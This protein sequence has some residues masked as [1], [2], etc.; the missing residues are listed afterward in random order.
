M[1]KYSLKER[2]RYRFDTIMSKGTVSMVSMLAA[3]TVAAA[4]LIAIAVSIFT[5]QEEGGFFSVLWDTLASI[6]NA[7]FLYSDDGGVGYLILMAAGALIGVLFTSVLIGIF[8]TEVEERLDAMKNGRSRIIEQGHMV[9]LG[10]HSGTFEV[11][12][13]LCLSADEGRKCIV[14]AGE[15]EQDVMRHAIKENVDVPKRIRV[16]C[17]S[18][19]IYDPSQ[20]AMLSI[21]DA[22]TV[23]IDSEHDEE[24]IRMMLAVNNVLQDYPES[25]VRIAAA[26]HHKATYKPAEIAGE[27]RADVL[28][29]RD[30]IARMITQT[31]VQ[32][33]ISDSLYQMF[34][35]EHASFRIKKIDEAEG[36]TFADVCGFVKED[37]PVGI[38]KGNVP[39]LNPGGGYVVQKGDQVIVLSDHTNMPVLD[40]ELP[41]LKQETALKYEVKKESGKIAVIGYNFSFEKIISILAEQGEK[42]VAA[43][44]NEDDLESVQEALEGMDAEIAEGDLMKGTLLA[45]TVKGCRHVVLLSDMDAEEN[46]ADG[47]TIMLLLRLR[48]LRSR[49]SHP[50][51]ITTEMRSDRN[52]DLMKNNEIADFIVSSDISAMMVVQVAE[53]PSLIPLFREVLSN[54]GND[55]MMIQ[56]SDLFIPGKK[57]AVSELRRRACEKNCIFAGYRRKD[58]VILNPDGRDTAVFTK[59]D[60]LLIFRNDEQ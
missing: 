14:V 42:I 54:H 12:R 26:L 45:D 13:Q 39:V 16:I 27:G 49:M 24:A 34:S 5:L 40:M 53:E 31:C 17:R 43:G 11:I 18:I 21:E 35:F 52:K 36:H 44:F 30:I 47:K 58:E 1:N 29:T 56:A 41:A 23:I 4:V 48:D 7:W 38:M 46:E 50:F 20:L 19:D 2:I 37:T 25:N 28:Q 3:L 33:G 32:T 59:D 60:R 9:L 57:Y 6:V 8:S 10:Y 15:E 22:H 55:M 51:S